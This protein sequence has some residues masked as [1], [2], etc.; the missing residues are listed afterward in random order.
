V[1]RQTFSAIISAMANRTEDPP[2]SRPPVGSASPS[3]PPTAVSPLVVSPAASP[4][5]P[6]TDDE[7]LT[8]EAFSA[9]FS[10]HQR[11]GRWE[12]ADDI[13]VR[14]FCGEVTLDF[15]L[16]DL[17]PSGMVEIDA[18]SICGEIHIIVPDGAEVELEGTPILGSIQQQARKKK[19]REAIREWVTGEREE[20]RVQHR[21]DEPPLFRIDAR[22]ILG[23]IKVTGR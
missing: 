22:A 3:V 4:A 13:E 1:I 2:K 9:T 10:S 12:A 19:A 8:H 17:P 18:Q 15:T 16:A 20:D 6:E 7:P 11:A 21:S 5:R 14:A 23:N